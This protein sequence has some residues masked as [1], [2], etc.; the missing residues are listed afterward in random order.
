MESTGN[1]KTDLHVKPTDMRQFL[2][3][4]SCHPDHATQNIPYSQVLCTLYANS[5]IETTKLHF[6]DLVDCLIKQG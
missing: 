5:N 6:R 3:A 4:T 1:I 2:L